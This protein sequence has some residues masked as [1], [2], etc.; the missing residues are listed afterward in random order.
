MC[1]RLLT[2]GSWGDVGSRA[3]DTRAGMGI[4]PGHTN[5]FTALSQ[6]GRV[7]TIQEYS[8]DL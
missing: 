5:T 3:L 7:T 6:H 1:V 8:L 4:V 2:R